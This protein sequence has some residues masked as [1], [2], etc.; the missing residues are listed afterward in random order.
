M[1]VHTSRSPCSISST[2]V[3][4][5]VQSS[6]SVVVVICQ[7]MSARR[8]EI[9]VLGSV[10]RRRREDVLRERAE[11]AKFEKAK[12]TA[13]ARPTPAYPGRFAYSR[14]RPLPH[15]APINPVPPPSPEQLRV[16]AVRQRVSAAEEAHLLE[17]AE[18]VARR[19]RTP[20][21]PRRSDDHYDL[22]K[23]ARRR[24]Y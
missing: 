15:R 12:M 1:T 4:S 20:T 18:R 10:A 23:W 7:A 2:T 5:I 9:V 19:P 14:H 11:I 17:E 24:W 22:A 13:Q 3:V 16:A 21:P 6:S 8:E